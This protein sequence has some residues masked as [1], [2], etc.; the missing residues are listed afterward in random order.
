MKA[1]AL[2]LLLAPAATALS[3]KKQDEQLHCQVGYSCIT[4]LSIE[5]TRCACR[6]LGHLHEMNTPNE[7]KL[8]MLRAIKEK[9]EGMLVRMRY[10]QTSRNLLMNMLGSKRDEETANIAEVAEG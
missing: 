5:A 3:L 6:I 10:R 1:V 9:D 4:G 8:A 7:D 2:F